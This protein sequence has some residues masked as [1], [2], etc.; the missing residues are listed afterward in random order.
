MSDRAS[1]KLHVKRARQLQRRVQR[2]VREMS[3]EMRLVNK[4]WKKVDQS[5]SCK[6]TRTNT[7]NRTR[8]KKARRTKASTSSSEA[9]LGDDSQEAHVEKPDTPLA[10]TDVYVKNDCVDAQMAWILKPEESDPSQIMCVV[11]GQAVVVRMHDG[12]EASAL[13]RALDLG[14][15][16][17]DSGVARITWYDESG[18]FEADDVVSLDCLQRE[19]TNYSLYDNHVWSQNVHRTIYDPRSWLDRMGHTEVAAYM[20]W[21]WTRALAKT[22]G[23]PNMPAQTRQLFDCVINV[24][25]CMG[26]EINANETLKCALEPCLIS[27]FR[28]LGMCYAVEWDNSPH[29]QCALCGITCG[30]Y[31]YK[32][33]FCKVS[34]DNMPSVKVIAGYTCA[35]SCVLAYDCVSVLGRMYDYSRSDSDHRFCRVCMKI[36]KDEHGTPS[37]QKHLD[38]HTGR[39]LYIRGGTVD[40]LAEDDK[41]FD[42]KK[43]LYSKMHCKC[44]FRPRA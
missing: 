19:H 35:A 34:E 23:Y 40:C 29:R 12:S 41:D 26:L 4:L 15:S 6:E 30:R 27:P 33:S 21:G 43:Y 39:L 18:V 25:L 20:C 9:S 5:I 31:L 36:P 2:I 11:P 17:H 1:L 3:V 32:L 38:M 16:S 7:E 13:I 37:V 14:L 10:R 28:R 44:N 24:A 22:T 42:A 8:R